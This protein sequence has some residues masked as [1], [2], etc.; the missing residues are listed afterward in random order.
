MVGSFSTT[1]NTM[2]LVPTEQSLP[3]DLSNHT[4]PAIKLPELQTQ[5]IAGWQYEIIREFIDPKERQ[6]PLD[7][8]AF[9]HNALLVSFIGEARPVQYLV[10]D[11]MVQGEF[12][13][14]AK[15]GSLGFA[16]H[17]PWNFFKK[18]IEEAK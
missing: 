7:Q 15:S 10:I 16:R 17:T 13:R 4:L 3:I 2:K 18:L 8:W 5:A 14:D 9:H 6:L 12:Y 11:E 1:R